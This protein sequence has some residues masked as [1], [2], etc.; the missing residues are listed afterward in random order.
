M[1]EMFSEDAR[2]EILMAK[3]REMT[4]LKQQLQRDG[5]DPLPAIL[6]IERIAKRLSDGNENPG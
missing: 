4:E 1:I 3:M 5:R 2:A 6:E